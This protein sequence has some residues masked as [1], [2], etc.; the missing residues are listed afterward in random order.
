MGCASARMSDHEPDRLFRNGEYEAA[1][2]KLRAGLEK[3]GE[4]GRDSLLY[5]LDLGLALHSAGKYD[6]S[7]QVFLKADKIAEIKDY[8]SLAAETTTL[9]ISDNIKDYKAEDFENVMISTYLAMDYALMGN[10]EDALVEARRVNHKL[11]LMINEGERKYKQNAFARYLSG[12]LYESNR[13][14]DEAY[15]DY[16]SVYKLAPEFP[17][18]GRDLWRCASILHMQDEM[19]KWDKQFSLSKEDHK[20]AN[21]IGKKSKKGEIIVLYENGISPI[22]RPNPVFESLPQFHPRFNPVMDAKVEVNGAEKGTTAVLENVEATAIENLDEKYGAIIAKKIA[23]IAVKEAVAY[24]IGRETNSPVIW[25][26]SRAL[27][28]ATDQADLRSWNLLPRDLQVLRIPIE[29]G[30]HTLRLTPSGSVNSL[31]EKIV[32]VAPGKKVF[33]NFRYMP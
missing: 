33:V 23:G 3:Q 11:E 2:Q 27:L 20:A 9:L 5:L 29:P 4:E 28:Y 26:V 1:T 12:I 31:P 19:K 30:T 13:D 25:L 16:K 22:K 32:Q 21:L 17:G 8:T 24:G 10:T 15:I 6:E 7:T 18:L 14:Y